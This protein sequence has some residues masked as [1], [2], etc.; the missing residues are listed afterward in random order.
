MGLETRVFRSCHLFLVSQHLTSGVF[1]KERLYMSSEQFMTCHDEDC[2]HSTVLILSLGGSL[3]VISTDTSP[4]YISS[5]HSL[6]R[7]KKKTAIEA[8]ISKKYLKTN[9]M[10]PTFWCILHVGLS[11]SVV[12][13]QPKDK[14]V[15]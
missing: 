5:I 3:P 1:I 12:R 14:E 8:F 2:L 15:L 4:I 6:Q 9:F 7:L 13:F 11:K 10:K